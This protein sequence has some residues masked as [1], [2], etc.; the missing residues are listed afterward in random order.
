VQAQLFVRDNAVGPGAVADSRG[1]AGYG[2]VY[3]TLF[4][5]PVRD[6]DAPPDLQ[7]FLQRLPRLHL[8]GG[9]TGGALD[10][11]TPLPT[12]LGNFATLH[13]SIAGGFVSTGAEGY[14]RWLYLALSAGVSYS[15]LQDTQGDYVFPQRSHLLILVS[16]SLGIRWQEILWTAGWSVTPQRDD[17][18]SFNVPF[19]GGAHAGFTA[20]LARRSQLGLGITVRDGG[21]SVT[22]LGQIWFSRRLGLGASLGGGHSSPSGLGTDIVEASVNVT[23]WLAS[24]LATGLTYDVWWQQQ[25][26]AVRT[27]SVAHT[28]SLDFRLRR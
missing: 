7:P 15:T 20:V 11:F 22:G 5:H 18:G 6:D 9:G 3:L 13:R 14:V 8:D 27:S 23:V 1:L 4:V 12:P 17:N 25:A 16:A 2:N 10:T 21:A 28:L 19:W 24:R 26:G